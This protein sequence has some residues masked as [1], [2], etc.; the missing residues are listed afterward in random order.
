[1]HAR[2]PVPCFASRP[3][4]ISLP[5]SWCSTTDSA[6]LGL[7]DVLGDSRKESL[8]DQARR[9]VDQATYLRHLLMTDAV[10][11]GI[12]GFPLA[13]TVECVLAIE[14]A[15]MRDMV[16]VVRRSP[17]ARD[18]CTRR[19][20][21]CCRSMKGPTIIPVEARR[22]VCAAAPV[23]AA[24]VGRMRATLG[25]ALARRGV[26]RLPVARP[27][28]LGAHGESSP[29]AAWRQRH[30]QILYLGS[31]R[32]SGHR[33]GRAYQESSEL[34]LRRRHPQRRSDPRNRQVCRCRCRTALAA[35]TR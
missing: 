4:S 23:H 17:P 3:I 8:A 22:V 20:W 12:P 35:A 32:G 25:P 27:A 21:T 26:V 5:R 2:V 15:R 16:D 18:F 1:M 19:G 33:L 14:T 31:S 24:T 10:A 11:A 7:S 6:R 29:P 34:Q 9:H 30:R 13:Y 28:A